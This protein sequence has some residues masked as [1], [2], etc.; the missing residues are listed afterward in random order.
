MDFQIQG[1]VFFD[2]FLFSP[3]K[4]KGK[5]A[6]EMDI[7]DTLITSGKERF[8]VKLNVIMNIE[9]ILINAIGIFQLFLDSSAL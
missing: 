6:S 5:C 3:G 7:V 2:F 8:L 4:N 1:R 9:N